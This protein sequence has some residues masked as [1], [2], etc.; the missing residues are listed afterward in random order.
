MR[1]RRIVISGL[2]GSTQFFYLI[3]QTTGLKKE[4]W[5]LDVFRDFLYNF[6]LKHTLL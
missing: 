2:S 6:R 4:I 1:M 3:S 5:T